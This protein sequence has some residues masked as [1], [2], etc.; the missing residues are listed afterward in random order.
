M[1][2]IFF[3]LYDI[4]W[5]GTVYAFFYKPL[6]FSIKEQ[7][8]RKCEKDA[9][10]TF[11]FYINDQYKSLKR[12]LKFFL[13]FF[14]LIFCVHVTKISNKTKVKTKMLI[15]KSKNRSAYFGIKLQ[16]THSQKEKIYAAKSYVKCTHL[17]KFLL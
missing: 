3:V 8:S 11:I 9:I 7:K 1:I 15:W 13:F 16:I 2:A 10:H 12:V 4:T 6:Y 17:N 14:H 5:I